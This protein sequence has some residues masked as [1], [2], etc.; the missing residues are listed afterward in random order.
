MRVIGY[1][2]ANGIIANSDGEYCTEPPFLDFLLEPKPESIKVFYHM[3]Y[4]V[5]NILRMLNIG[6]AQAKSLQA[7]GQLLAEPYLIKHRAGKFMSIKKGHY[8]SS[9]F[10]NFSDMNQYKP[11]SFDESSE[12]S[13]ADCIAKA[14]EAQKT[15]EEV[16]K[17]LVELGLHPTSLTSPINAYNKEVLSK[18]SLP[19]VD[20][21]PEEAAYYAYQCVQG[22]WL[23]AFQIGHWEKAYDYDINSA[24]PSELMKLLDIRLGKWVKSK[25]WVEEAVYGFCKGVVNIKASISPIIY[26]KDGG[27]EL[28]YT[29]TGTW[30]RY[31]TKK[32]VEFLRYY[33]RGDFKLEDGWWW[34]P[35]KKEKILANLVEQIYWQKERSTG[36]AREVTKRVMSGIWGLFL[37]T[38]KEGFGD[39][40]NPAYGAEVESN[41][42]LEDAKFIILNG[43]DPIHVSVDGVLS[44]KK[45]LLGLEN[46]EGRIGRWELA[47]EDSAICAGT[48]AV[49]IKGRRK[50]AD[51]S[52][53]YDW[54]VGEIG[55]EPGAEE[56]SMSKLSPITLA[57][58]L[59][60]R[61]WEKLGELRTITKKVHMG[62]EMKRRYR[63]EPKCGRE[64]LSRTY[65]SEPWDVSLLNNP[66]K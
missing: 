20:D 38:Q 16:Y 35:E 30:E 64:L 37:Q 11:A 18:V 17:A 44:P 56:Y 27:E 48:A 66:G 34:I 46:G 63:E 54:L 61:E 53:D 29:P 65:G 8:W 24:Y 25:E 43:I 39:L 60:S 22:N 52:I 9:P 55:K 10:A 14:K 59:N 62:G 42:R 57:V 6:E 49:A 32:K 13:V 26:S 28:S 50:A 12:S 3:E 51:F 7:N 19:T 15:G 58:A 47:S 1:H 4:S 31:L 5:A 40:F 23:E 41:I 33:N 36:I 21:M 2:A 45:V